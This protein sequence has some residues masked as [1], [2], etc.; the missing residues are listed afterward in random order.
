MLRFAYFYSALL[1]FAQAETLELLL[2]RR[3]VSSRSQRMAGVLLVVGVYPSKLEATLNLE[4]N[5]TGWFW[6]K[7][8]CHIQIRVALRTKRL[9]ESCDTWVAD[10]DFL[11]LLVHVSDFMFD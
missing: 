3:S 7:R 6:S 1:C 4:P 5:L 8:Q 9:P 2:L 11:V 10:L